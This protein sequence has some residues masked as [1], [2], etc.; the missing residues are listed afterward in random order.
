MEELS[1]RFPVVRGGSYF[2]SSGLV[3]CASRPLYDP[4]DRDADV[5]F[6]VVLY[7]FSSGL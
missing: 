2:N 7:P 5:G 3:N 6:R 4:D 1:N